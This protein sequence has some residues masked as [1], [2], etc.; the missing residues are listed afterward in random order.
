MSIEEQYI[1]R[2]K[3]PYVLSFSD[4]HIVRK[5]KHKSIMGVRDYL[6]EHVSPLLRDDVDYET[7]QKKNSPIEW[8]KFYWL[9]K[10]WEI[11][12][13]EENPGFWLISFANEEDAMMFEL[14][15]R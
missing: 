5:T 4:Y 12:S 15:N 2:I 9:G 1:N 11:D 3:K 10:T 8:Y 7:W 14:E 13:D 6:I